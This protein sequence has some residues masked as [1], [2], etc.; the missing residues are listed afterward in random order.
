L[1]FSPDGERFVITSTGDDSER[2]F[3]V[4][5]LSSPETPI[6][7]LERSISYGSAQFSPDGALLAIA[8]MSAEFGGP[9]GN[10]QLWDID[11]NTLVADWTTDLSGY[12]S[13]SPDGTLLAAGVNDRVGLWDVAATIELAS[14]EP[15]LLDGAILRADLKYPS[16][17]NRLRAVVFSPDGNWLAVTIFYD[18][19]DEPEQSSEYTTYLWS[20]PQILAQGREIGSEQ[21]GFIHIP[22]AGERLPEFS[23]DSQLLATFDEANL[24]LWEVEAVVNGE[25][26][27]LVT[28]TSANVQEIA[29]NPDGTL[30]FVRDTSSVSLWGVR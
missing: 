12:H 1:E 20:L 23:R 19:V 3:E 17:Y 13:F 22:L 5:E 11:H 9:P 8:N 29:F 25:S 6:T 2:I 10:E 21:E 24:S 27:P 4:R 28:L 30:L 18:P 15:D 16:R 14:S 7:T 26:S